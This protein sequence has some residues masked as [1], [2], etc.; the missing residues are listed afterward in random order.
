VPMGFDKWG[1][2]RTSC[3]VVPTDAPAKVER[4]K[5]PS[6]VAGAI[7]ELL[8][9]KAPAGMKRGDIVKHYAERYYKSVVYRELKKMLDSGRL[10]EVDGIYTLRAAY[11]SEAAI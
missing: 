9:G 10:H 6:E 2:L 1:S 7:T 3:N 4:G 11:T 5:R 8:N